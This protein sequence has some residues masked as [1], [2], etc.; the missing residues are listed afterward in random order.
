MFYKAITHH[1]KISK[2]VLLICPTYMPSNSLTR[3]SG[4]VH[5][6]KNPVLRY[7]HIDYCHKYSFLPPEIISAIANC[8]QLTTLVQTRNFLSNDLLLQL[9]DVLKERLNWH[10]LQQ[11]GRSRNNFPVHSLHLCR[12]SSNRSFYK[13]LL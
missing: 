13:L 6:F 3:E 7:L 4:L 5:L 2:L 10:R 12:Q 1:P 9:S 8:S 11:L